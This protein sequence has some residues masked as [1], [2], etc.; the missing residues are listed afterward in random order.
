MTMT[1]VNAAVITNLERW[2]CRVQRR[3]HR[4]DYCDRGGWQLGAVALGVAGIGLNTALTN[5]TVN[6]SQ[7]FTA[8]MTAAALAAAPTGTINLNGGVT[9]D[10]TLNV[11]LGRHHRLRVADRQQRRSGRRHH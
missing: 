9:T 5:V 6:A 8:L 7:D 4:P 2:G 10:V 11:D 3:H 1:G